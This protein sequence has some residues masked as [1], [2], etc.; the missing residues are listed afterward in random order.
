MSDRL[1]KEYTTL[2]NMVDIVEADR[3]QK[4]SANLQKV[5]PDSILETRNTDAI[6][7]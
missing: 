1:S 7:T 2:K 4:L 3:L 5:I 6:K